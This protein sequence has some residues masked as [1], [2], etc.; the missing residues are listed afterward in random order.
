MTL[1]AL[2]KR[3]GERSALRDLYPSA[4][5]EYSELQARP[6][7]EALAAVTE[8]AES[9]PRYEILDQ[10]QSPLGGLVLVSSVDQHV[11]LCATV[12]WGYVRPEARGAGL[13]SRLLREAIRV[14]KKFGIP[15][16]AYS[17]RVGPGEYLLRYKRIR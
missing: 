13:Y 2:G 14:S 9:Y 6:L 12:H 5:S 17:H 11:G 15:Y 3:P 8:A 1:I 16:F 7:H 4:W 10:E